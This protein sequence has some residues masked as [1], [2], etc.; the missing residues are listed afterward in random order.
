MKRR[1]RGFSPLN[2][3]AVIVGVLLSASVASAQQIGGAIT[4]DQG[5]GLPGVVVEARSPSMI[6]EVRTT[7]SDGNGQYVIVALEPGTYAVTYTLDGFSTLIRDGIELTTG[8]TASIDVSLAVGN[9]Q[10]T[11]T[12]TGATPVVDIQNNL[13]RQIID[14]E[15]IDTVPTGKSFQSYA[16][17]VPGMNTSQQFGTSLNQ[18]AGG[19]TAQTMGAL[20]IHGGLPGDGVTALNGMD[21]TVPSSGGTGQMFGLV[22]DGAMEEM[23]VEIS[24]HS[25]E[26]E[27]GGVRV[28]LI[29]REGANQF[30]G[31]FFG[32]YTNPSMQGSN[33]DDDLRSRGVENQSELDRAWL[34]N[35]S[36]GGPIVEDR[37]W[38]FAQHTAQVADSFTPNVFAD[39]TP[40]A[41][42]YVADT[43]RPIAGENSTYDTSLNFTLQASEKDKFKIYY[44]YS[45]W[46]KPNALVGPLFTLQISPEASLN[47]KY[48]V[49]TTQIGWVRPQNSRLLYE[50]NVSFAPATFDVDSNA[51]AV[52]NL[53][54][55]LNLP[56]F[57]IS[58]NQHFIAEGGHYQNAR[59]TAAF[60]GA[61]TWVNGTHNIRAGANGTWTKDGRPFHNS[62]SNWTDII[63]IFGTP[64]TANFRLP[65]E[66]QV[67][68]LA[69]G[70]FVQDQMTFDKLTVNAGLRLDRLENS[71]PDQSRRPSTWEPNGQS[72]L[73]NSSVVGWND[74]QP[75][76]GFAYDV[77][78]TGKTALKASANR[79]GARANGRFAEQV[80][81]LFANRTESRLWL[82]G[83]TGSPFIGVPIGSLPSCIPS[84]ADPTGSSCIAGDGIPQGDPLSPFPNGELLAPMGN[85]A[86][87]ST[88]LTQFLDPNWSHGWGKRLSNWEI[89]AGVQQELAPGVS[90]D[91]T[92]FRRDYVNFSI[93]DNRAVSGD[94]Y[95]F[96]TVDLSDRGIEGVGSVTFPEIR[97]DALSRL[98]DVLSTSADQF[99]GENQSYTGVDLTVNARLS[100]LLLQGGLNTGKTSTD[101]C[102]TYST[103][104]EAIGGRGDLVGGNTIAREFCDASTAWLTQFKLLGTYTMPYDIQVAATLQ[105]SP[106][107]ERRAIVS[108][109]PAEIAAALGRPQA[110]PG[111]VPIN[112][113]APG[114]EYGERFN[115]FDLRLTKVVPTT[116]ARLRFMLDI[117]NLFNANSVFSENYGTGATYLTPTGFMP[118]RLFRLSVQADF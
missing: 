103:V 73:G 23:S 25:A 17:L 109:S 91:V 53:P 22:S 35:P 4:D 110:S 54:G 37:L 34:V 30:S 55:V 57:R 15:V 107:P 69:Y 7:V 115:Q 52:T 93:Q 64:L 108:V 98:P 43:S 106:G 89:T 40:A 65:N 11:L 67:R 113:L 50:A 31:A 78:G 118:P 112:A 68:G 16:L 20:A 72:I 29:P 117:F 5:L 32:T 102:P 3:C 42:Q 9:V 26:A 6:E 90:L 79:Y 105:S 81:P 85:A 56:D 46:R 2:A 60:R 95:D 1:S 86:F 19:T 12:V 100:Q 62:D 104:P 24:G 101:F 75:R 45:D 66:A 83:G 49:N 14:R 92:M 21:V 61:V 58:R 47:S 76:L 41:Q 51:D 33:L 71:Y 18:D 13:Q 99:G 8:F 94:D 59:N 10:E 97:P 44:A 87:G 70:L 74:L 48:T 88:A 114:S 39:L 38:F 116:A 27:L 36:L 77:F 84:A 82:D 63:T 28:N 111:A 80:N 96:V